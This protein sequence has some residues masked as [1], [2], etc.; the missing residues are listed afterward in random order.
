MKYRLSV[1]VTGIAL[2]AAAPAEGQLWFMPDVPVPAM[3][4]STPA[5]WIGATYARNA[6][7]DA[8]SVDAF[9]AHFGR[10][11][12]VVSFMGSVGLIDDED[13]EF[14]FGAAVGVEMV[15]EESVAISIQGGASWFSVDRGVG[16]N[17]DFLRFPIGLAIRGWPGS[18]EDATSVQPWL[19]PRLDI[20]RVSGFEFGDA[21][22]E[23]DLGVSG[24]VSFSFREAWGIFTALD[25]HPTAGFDPIV[26]G[27]GVF[28]NLGRGR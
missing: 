9:G 13:D 16:Q 8:V 20:S 22:T 2:L 10:T 11:G 14:M 3:T 26:F 7:D 6:N 5:N 24:G 17:L 18:T 4:G 12:R 27:L 25:Y 19:M 21:F 1:L 28:F 15:R 23:F